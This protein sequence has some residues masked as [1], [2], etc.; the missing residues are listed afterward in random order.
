MPAETHITFHTV[1]RS[2]EL[3]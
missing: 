3:Q 1:L 2:S